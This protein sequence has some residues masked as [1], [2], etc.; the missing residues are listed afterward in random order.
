MTSEE[1]FCKSYLSAAADPLIDSAVAYLCDKKSPKKR[2]NVE[3]T[4]WKI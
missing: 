1:S 3:E 2:P 4:T